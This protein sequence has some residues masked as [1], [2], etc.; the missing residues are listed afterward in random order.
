MAT[1]AQLREKL[2][3][4]VTAREADDFEACLKHLDSASIMLAGIATSD[5]DGDKLDWEATKTNFH[6]T[7][8]Q[9]R[10][11]AQA[12]QASSAGGIVSFDIVYKR[13]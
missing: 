10:Q 5:F 3:Q 8:T 11:A 13:C 2:K 7:I 9:I 6:R 4:A 1:L 12:A